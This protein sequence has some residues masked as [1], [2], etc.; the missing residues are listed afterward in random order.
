VLAQGSVLGE[1][2]AERVE[3]LIED[4]TAAGGMAP[5]LR[6]AARAAAAG[7][8]R[9]RIGGVEMLGDEAAGTRVHAALTAE[10]TP[11]GALG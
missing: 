6:A 1:I 2:G 3:A 4:G 5:K 9:V 8:A 11:Q 10:T 7:V